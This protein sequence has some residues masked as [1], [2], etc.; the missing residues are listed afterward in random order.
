MHDGIF[1]SKGYEVGKQNTS[2]ALGCYASAAVTGDLEQMA[3]VAKKFLKGG[4]VP[5]E[6]KIAVD[7][8]DAAAKSGSADAQ[9]YLAKCYQSG[10]SV[11][12]DIG[13]A[14]SLYKTASENGHQGAKIE[15]Q[16]I[17]GALSFPERLKYKIKG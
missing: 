7:I 2:S 1:L 13:K 16:G 10:I 8:L 9:F 5:K 12:A 6:E 15:L 4:E 11:N 14:I 17:Q 3:D